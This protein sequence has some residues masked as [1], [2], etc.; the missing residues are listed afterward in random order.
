MENI[1]NMESIRFLE[2]LNRFDSKYKDN[3]S[4]GNYTKEMCTE[5]CNIG[6]DII[7]K[8]QVSFLED[9]TVINAYHPNSRFKHRCYLDNILK[10]L[11]KV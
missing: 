8:F 9:T 2:D 10:F 11:R 5:F 3:L 4:S 6:I 7:D 1:N